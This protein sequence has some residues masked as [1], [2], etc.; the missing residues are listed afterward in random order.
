MSGGKFG[1]SPS[2]GNRV[3]KAGTYALA[4]FKLL[5][6]YSYVW[7]KMSPQ[8]AHSVI[9]GQFP[10]PPGETKIFHFPPQ[11][12][13]G[14]NMLNK[15]K[16]QFPPQSTFWKTFWGEMTLC[17]TL[18][19]YLS[20]I[21]LLLVTPS[22]NIIGCHRCVPHQFLLFCEGTWESLTLAD[23]DHCR[24]NLCESWTSI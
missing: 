13:A 9:Q 11:K 16:H 3:P 4:V 2:I 6:L 12:L 15:G 22:Y 1:P 23:V 20:N 10:H 5:L 24:S 14:R 17:P 19:S 21:L 8:S 18:T 7:W